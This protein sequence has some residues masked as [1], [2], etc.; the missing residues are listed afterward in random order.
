MAITDSI[1]N[2][3]SKIGENKDSTTNSS[4]QQFSQDIIDCFPKSV[5]NKISNA[6]KTIIHINDERTNTI[7][8]IIAVCPKILSMTFKN[9]WET[10]EPYKMSGGSWIQ[11]G[12]QTSGAENLS[13]PLNREVST[14]HY[15][16][17]GSPIEMSLTIQLYAEEYK[18]VE[19]KIFKPIKKLS[20]LAQPSTTEGGKL[21]SPGPSPFKF[22]VKYRGVKLKEVRT[23]E[24]D[25]NNKRKLVDTDYKTIKGTDGNNLYTTYEIDAGKGVQTDIKIG[26]W[27]Y[28]TDILVNNVKIDIPMNLAKHYRYTTGSLGQMESDI[29]DANTEKTKIENERRTRISSINKEIETNK[30]SLVTLKGDKDKITNLRSSILSTTNRIK[31]VESDINTQKLIKDGLQQK[32]EFYS[33]EYKNYLNM[34]LSS[35]NI[36]EVSKYSKKSME[37]LALLG[38]TNIDISNTENKLSSLNT[39]LI[40]LQ[41][42]KTDL[43]SSLSS[44]IDKVGG[45]ENLNKNIK[46]LEEKGKNLSSEKKD[47]DAQKDKYTQEMNRI[48]NNANTYK[49]DLKSDAQARPFMATITLDIKTRYQITQND[50]N[51]IL[52]GEPVNKNFVDW[53]LTESNLSSALVDS[54]VKLSGVKAKDLEGNVVEE[55][56]VSPST[57]AHKAAKS[58]G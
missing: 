21:V 10:I 12:V 46:S 2:Y 49:N 48:E 44:T 6:Y 34:S 4:D 7:S 37:S 41:N 51:S 14:I 50:F 56:V 23:I 40:G 5:K 47:L 29:A 54:F 28:L 38:S 36:T 55:V 58:K 20:N 9:S 27:F 18:D 11:A 22:K 53:D 26:D 30:K 32:K 35:T 25:K 3:F 16:T 45:E 42:T 52:S 57:L 1:N 39:E 17:G 19:E 43:E 31:T 33:E 24:V 8:N 15:W 13:G